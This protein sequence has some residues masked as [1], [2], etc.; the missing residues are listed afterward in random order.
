MQMQTK[1]IIE[2]NHLPVTEADIL[3][4]FIEFTEIARIT[5]ESRMSLISLYRKVIHVGLQYA[6]ENAENVTFKE[7]AAESLAVRL[8]RRPST[9]ADLR[10]YI[11]RFL[12]IAPWK[13]K[14]IRFITRNE[15]RKMLEEHFSISAH[16]YM[17]AKS[18]LNS[19][20]AYALKQGW[21]DKNPVSS[22]LS[23]V[24]Q[25]ERIEILTTKQISSLMKAL[26]ASDLRCMQAAVRLMLWCGIRP[27]E[28]QRL[29]WSDVNF[30]EKEVYIESHASK[31]GGARAVPLRGGALLLYQFK[32]KPR[33]LIAPR[34]WGRLWAKLRRRAGFKVWQK[35]SLRHTF[36]SMHLKCFHNI[37]LLQEEMGHRDSGLLRTRYL[38]LRNLTKRMASDFFKAEYP[39]ENK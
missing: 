6:E 28:V 16:V 35:D 38:N 27:G 15:C 21:C 32:G 39:T 20:F 9:L 1:P 18:I 29:R 4:L 25:E 22:I 26:R 12:N 8:H 34:N 23:R 31:T 5:D 14:N 10:S 24:I 37:F 33:D 30:R 19:I 11:N 36:A 17:K 3:R 13:E 7:A 2:I